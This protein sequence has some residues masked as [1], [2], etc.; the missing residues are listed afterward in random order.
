MVG[1]PQLWL[2]F[3]CVACHSGQGCPTMWEY[4]LLGE[5]PSFYQFLSCSFSAL[6]VLQTS[7]PEYQV[8]FN[9]QSRTPGAGLCPSSPVRLPSA[10]F[11]SPSSS[12]G[13]Q[14]DP[15]V[16][17]ALCSLLWKRNT[18]N[19]CYGCFQ[20]DPCIVSCSSLELC[21]PLCISLTNSFLQKVIKIPWI[22]ACMNL[23]TTRLFSSAAVF[24][25]EE[26]KDRVPFLLFF[27]SFFLDKRIYYK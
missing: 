8:L 1:L 11:Y 26:D 19:Q 10:H 3:Q 12:P 7:F 15:P 24:K 21:H 27:Y 13:W 5:V 23:K 2:L 18:K 14:Q 20:A 17:Q 9:I 16:Q 6:S 22:S 25:L 4:L